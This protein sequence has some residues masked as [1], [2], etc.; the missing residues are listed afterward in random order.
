MYYN[1]QPDDDLILYE[2]LA[3]I[4][5]ASQER[6]VSRFLKFVHYGEK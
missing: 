6:A 3:N 5:L 2:G 1:D 4:A